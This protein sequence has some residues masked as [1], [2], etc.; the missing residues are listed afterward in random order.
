MLQY[1]WAITD[2]ITAHHPGEFLHPKADDYEL[3]NDVS[4]YLCLFPLDMYSTI[5][6][7]NTHFRALNLHM[8]DYCLP[9]RTCTTDVLHHTPN[10]TIG[11]LI[12]IS[13]PTHTQPSVMKPARTE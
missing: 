7:F 9:T 12:E 11:C 8:M 1:A 5:R 10:F 2:A 6:G 4:K 13:V 3:V